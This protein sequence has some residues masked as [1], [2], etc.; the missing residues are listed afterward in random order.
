MLIG[1]GQ[2]LNNV[3]DVFPNLVVGP[4]MLNTP[5]LRFK[6]FTE[7]WEEKLL[8]KIIRTIAA[9]N[10]E[11]Q[12]EGYYPLYGSTGIIGRSKTKHYFGKL[13]LI[14]RVGADA[15]KLQ[16]ID[17]E[18]DV[19]DNALIISHTDIMEENKYNLEFIYYGISAVNIKKYTFGSAQPLLTSTIIKN[20]SITLPSLPEQQEIGNFFRSQDEGIAAAEKQVVKL[21]T[22]KQA[23]LQ[24]MFA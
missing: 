6:G 24:Q 10:G 16:F 15:G 21:K 20:V 3:S 4:A 9:G 13:I 17:E 5:R 22:V 1:G 23:C 18:C 11:H 2:K 12:D 8:G 14:A 19:T 7:P